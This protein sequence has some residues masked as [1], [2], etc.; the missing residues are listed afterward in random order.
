MNWFCYICD[1]Q[2]VP[3]GQ[4]P[5][6][7]ERTTVA[8]MAPNVEAAAAVVRDPRWKKADPSSAATWT[9]DFSNIIRTLK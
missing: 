7:R 3:P 1:D 2:D 4:R 5:R 6:G 8:L 9:D